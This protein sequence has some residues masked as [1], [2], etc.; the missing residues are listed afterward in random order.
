LVVVA[1]VVVHV[2]ILEWEGPWGSP[3]L[4]VTLVE[5]ARE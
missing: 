4:D 3:A 5:E 1:A 2:K